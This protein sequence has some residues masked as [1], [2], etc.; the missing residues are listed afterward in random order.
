MCTYIYMCG[1]M[2]DD[3][4]LYVC[5]P[6]ADFRFVSESNY[7]RG[8]I[9]RAGER[10]SIA[11][12]GENRSFFYFLVFLFCRCLFA[13]AVPLEDYFSLSA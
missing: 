5:T 12:I 7:N 8:L 10:E 4:M 6:R 11:Y 1:Y 13:A 3:P 9:M 2:L